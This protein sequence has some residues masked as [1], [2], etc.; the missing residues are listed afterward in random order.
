MIEELKTGVLL[1][2]GS[3]NNVNMKEMISM[4]MALPNTPSP[5]TLF[6]ALQYRG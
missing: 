6:P 3:T 5:F 4:L 2:M 1:H